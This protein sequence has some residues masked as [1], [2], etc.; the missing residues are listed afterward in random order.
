MQDSWVQ[1]V[2]LKTEPGEH[3]HAKRIEYELKEVQYNNKGIRSDIIFKN[4]I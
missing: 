2:L 3:Y 4:V 1:S